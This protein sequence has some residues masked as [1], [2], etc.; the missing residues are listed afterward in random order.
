MLLNLK[1]L[2]APSVCPQAPVTGE[3]D[4]IGL[5]GSPT[6]RSLGKAIEGYE[7]PQHHFQRGVG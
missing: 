5:A 3:G 6:P 1:A 2:P 7:C 4:E